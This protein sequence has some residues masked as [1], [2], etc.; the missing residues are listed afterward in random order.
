M[1]HLLFNPWQHFLIYGV[2]HNYQHY[3]KRTQSTL[4]VTPSLPKEYFENVDFGGPHIKMQCIIIN[5]LKS[6]WQPL[7][8]CPQRTLCTL[9]KIM[10]IL[11]EPLK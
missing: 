6:V 8:P 7:T 9:V 5:I 4:F 2:V 10:T 1:M 3:Q 11:D